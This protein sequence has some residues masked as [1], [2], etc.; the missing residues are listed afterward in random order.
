MNS[1]A[2]TPLRLID[3]PLDSVYD[4]DETHQGPLIP[5]YVICTEDVESSGIFFADVVL[6]GYFLGTLKNQTTLKTALAKIYV[7][8]TLFIIAH[9]D[10]SVGYICKG[11]VLISKALSL[12]AGKVNQIIFMMCYS[13]EMAQRSYNITCTKLARNMQAILDKLSRGVSMDV[14]TPLPQMEIQGFVGIGRGCSTSA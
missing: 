1:T 2:W 11:K 12:A 6:G 5:Q 9:S 14:D 13:S 10:D 4:I 8:G 3:E 7:P